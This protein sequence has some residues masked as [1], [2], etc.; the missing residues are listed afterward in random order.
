MNCSDNRH[1]KAG[2]L[3]NAIALPQG[4]LIVVLDTNFLSTKQLC[5]MAIS[6]FLNKQNTFFQ[7]ITKIE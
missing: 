7:K 5:S 2:N 1:A 4:K 6:R 3:N